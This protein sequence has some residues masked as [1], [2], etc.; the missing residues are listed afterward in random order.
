MFAQHTRP[1]RWDVAY[2]LNQWLAGKCRIYCM[3]IGP[4]VAN[5][6]RRTDEVVD[7]QFSHRNFSW[8]KTVCQPYWFD[9]RVQTTE[10]WL[11]VSDEI[12]R[13][14]SIKVRQLDRPAEGTFLFVIPPTPRVINRYHMLYATTG[15]LVPRT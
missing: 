15:V 7:V 5:K 13:G 8:V 1:N 3:P 4:R 6:M 10:G 12:E 9:L 14:R 2:W 11:T